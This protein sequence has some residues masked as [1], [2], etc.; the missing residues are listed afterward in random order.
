LQPSSGV[1]FN[2]A[3]PGGSGKLDVTEVTSSKIKGTFSYV[4]VAPDGSKK[5]V[6]DGSFDVPI[7]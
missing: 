2:S 5:T 7:K 6:T 1:L 4:G 3:F